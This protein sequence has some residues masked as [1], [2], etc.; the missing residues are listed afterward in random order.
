[1]TKELARD[2]P[3]FDGLLVQGA[4][5]MQALASRSDELSQL[6]SNTNQAD[7]RDQ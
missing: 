3:S 2:E 6:V 7:R 4:K 5:A 1:M